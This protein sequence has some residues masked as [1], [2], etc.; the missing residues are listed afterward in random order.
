MNNFP[1]FYLKLFVN[2]PKEVLQLIYNFAKFRD[3]KY[4]MYLFDSMDMRSPII[5]QNRTIETLVLNIVLFTKTN[6]LYLESDRPM[7]ANMLL[8]V[9][10]KK[11]GLEPDTYHLNYWDLVP[12]RYH[13]HNLENSGLA[14]KKLPI[15]TDVRFSKEIIPYNYHFSIK[16]YFEM[17]DWEK[18][19]W[20]KLKSFI[21]ENWK[22]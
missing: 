14:F 15:L 21:L 3:S 6:P 9:S 16:S 2:H 13:N 20:N 22:I 18:K 8:K 12:G 19:N 1:S 17:D 11:K 4:Y 7:N 5:K 10:G